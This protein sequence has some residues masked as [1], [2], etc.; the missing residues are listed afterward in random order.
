M[1]TIP[2]KTIDKIQFGILSRERNK[3]ISNGRIITKYTG[4][5]FGRT[6]IGSLYDP[7]M[8]T[9]KSGICQT[10][11]LSWATCPGHPGLIELKI[12]I[13]N[14]LFIKYVAG[15]LKAT[16]FKCSI[17]MVHN[18]DHENIL[19]LE[20]KY[21]LA[22]CKRK[23]TQMK[24]CPVCN[25]N[26][27]G[28]RYTT[29][30]SY[31]IKYK[32]P[33]EK[34]K[35]LSEAII[36]EKLKRLKNR[37]II[38]MGFHPAYSHPKDMILHNLLVSPPSTR[39]ISS[40]FGAGGN[41]TED[42][43]FKLYYMVIKTNG[44][45]EYDISA[46]QVKDDKILEGTITM[47]KIA[48][49]SL[50][51]DRSSIKKE[52]SLLSLSGGGRPLKSIKAKLSTKKG[53][54]R[55]NAL[56][57]RLNWSARTV[58]SGDSSIDIDEVGVPLLVC[59]KLCMEI[60][61]NH[62]NINKLRKYVENGPNIWPGARYIK[63]LSTGYRIM[64]NDK[65][66][67]QAAANLQYGDIVFRHLQDGD[68]VLFNRQPT[69]HKISIMS[70]R[71][72]I[73]TDNHTFRLHNCATSPYNAD[74]D[75]DEMNL[76]R[77]TNPYSI[78]EANEILSVRKR[79][80][81]E[82]N[83]E[84]VIKPIQDNIL[85]IYLMSKH[86]HEKLTKYKFI[87]ILSAGGMYRRDIMMQRSWKVINLLESILPVD[88]TLSDDHGLMFKSGR[89]IHGVIKSREM[90]YII[91]NMYSF[92]GDIATLKF[93]KAFQRI[94]DRFLTLH[95]VTI[96]IRD[97]VINEKI[98]SKLKA[99]IKNASVQNTE[100]LKSFNLGKINIPITQ[101]PSETFERLSKGIISSCLKK[102]Q[103]ILENHLIETG[104][105]FVDQYKSG[106][107][108]KATNVYQIFDALGQQDMN[109]KRIPHSFGMRTLPYYTKFDNSLE[110]RG[111]VKNSFSDGLNPIGY[112]YHAASARNGVI[113]TALKTAD[114]GYVSRE[115]VNTQQ[116]IML[117]YDHFIR[118]ANKEIVSFS[119]GPNGYNT[120][121][122][123]NNKL[124]LRGLT[125]KEFNDLYI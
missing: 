90:S 117:S 104:N 59:M 103:D 72:K 69:L 49:T 23:A 82:S 43:L 96:S 54:F 19:K 9:I 27:H 21:R 46:D 13:L 98:K 84:T 86:P 2:I 14:P 109:G 45:L 31:N 77:I 65:I 38:L 102:N 40:G 34:A 76:F 42:E 61:V 36:Y 91:K 73:F 124:K 32:H 81:S 67:T 39:P 121:K 53:F 71:V 74:F 18:R 79:V 113:D 30:V 6:E 1:T 33:N 15:I 12:P 118:H 94:T 107:R 10:C 44:K 78:A 125:K 123:H 52:H 25:Y 115:S 68:I 119:Y 70:H 16:C 48:V 122:L 64:L 114:T 97:C 24:I 75:G 99:N 85:S 95:G 106:S 93:M 41:R 120:A 57:K 101:S 47:L 62:R 89:W 22:V 20:P 100:L 108:G 56:G 60:F 105:H 80:I 55:R 5:E 63:K 35:V 7:R 3:K 111:F 116:S 92:Y 83:S 4:H 17:L 66:K 8:G 112:V 110:S 58:I 51:T 11:F 29:E 37:E 87:T 88:F 50:I 28:M 26:N